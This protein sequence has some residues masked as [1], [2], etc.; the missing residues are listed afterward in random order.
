M[1]AYREQN[2][3]RSSMTIQK[4]QTECVCA[5]YCSPVGEVVNIASLRSLSPWNET[6]AVL[7]GD[8]ESSQSLVWL[9]R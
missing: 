4:F 1:D 2:Q 5:C 3:T 8:W 6:T 9:Q 7:L